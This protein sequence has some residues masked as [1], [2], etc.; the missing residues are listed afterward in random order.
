MQAPEVYS[1][2]HG[3]HA[4]DCRYMRPGLA[5]SHVV[6]RD[7]RA[8]FVDTGA[9]SSVRLL[10]A[11]LDEL[12]ISPANVDYVFLTHVHLDHAGG[13]GLLMRSLPNAMAVVHPR[14]AE[15]L[16]D[17]S[18]LEAGTR[19]VYGD[20]VYEK[21]YGRLV[22]LP[23]ERIHTVNDGDILALADS[24]FEF[25]HTPGHALHHVA[26]H[27]ETGNA[28]FAGDSFGISYRVFDSPRGRAFIF[29]TTT[30]TQFDP[31]QM[32]GSIDRIVSLE[33]RAVYLMHFGEVTEIERLAQ[34]LRDDI[35]RFVEFAQESAHDADQEATIRRKMHDYLTGRLAAHGTRPDPAVRETWLT[36]DVRLNAAGLVAW[37]ERIERKRDKGR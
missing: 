30:P 7:G 34:D 2:A 13:A 1:Y 37:R 6:I 20:A 18:R 26:I 14:G 23:E 8:A 22:P 9:N 17:P 27:D 19:A 5:A 4:V 21:L 3:I 33:P 24:R 29:P 32:H 31:E 15:H 12:D 16:I 25:L 35:E 10:L 28:V 36:S 11:A